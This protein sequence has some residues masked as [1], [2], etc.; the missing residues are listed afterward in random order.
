VEVRK[1]R[2]LLVS[3]PALSRVIRHLFHDRL[4]FEVV[5]SLR[6]FRSLARQADR[7]R[8]ELIVV[9]VKPVSTGV[10]AVVVAIKASSPFS[11]LILICPNS[12]LI[13][14]ARRCG[15]DACID[16]EN[17]VRGLVPMASGLSTHFPRARSRSPKN[18]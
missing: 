17:L 8:P 14:D 5:G 1:I 10:C 4:G 16:Q 6:G 2:I 7:L 15:A 18:H 12:E 9:N 3:S 13:S 11:K